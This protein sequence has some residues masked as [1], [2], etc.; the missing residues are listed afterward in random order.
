ML[1]PSR[2]SWN[3]HDGCMSFC[4]MYSVTVTSNWKPTKQWLKQDTELFHKVIIIANTYGATGVVALIW[5]LHELTSQPPYEAVC[6][7]SLFYQWGIERW[8]CSCSHGCLYGRAGVLTHCT[9][10]LE[11][12][13]PLHHID[14]HVTRCLEAGGP[15][16]VWRLPYIIKDPSS[17]VF[18]H[19][20]TTL[21]TDILFTWW[22]PQGCKMDATAT[23]IMPSHKCPKHEG[24]KGWIESG[25]SLSG[26]ENLP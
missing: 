8:T 17:W 4:R 16:W 20:I 11:S 21:H 1:A 14:L 2:L 22:L 26:S 5:A 19:T 15:E 6:L 3:T 7:L 12:T 10:V 24:G 23:A 9:Q 25:L 18:F 13:W